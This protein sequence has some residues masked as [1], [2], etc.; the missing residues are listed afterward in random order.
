MRK[1]L[2]ILLAIGI[3]GATF[4]PLSIPVNA[5]ES[6]TWSTNSTSAYCELHKR[7]ASYATAQS[8]A[9]G[10]VIASSIIVVK[11][12][13]IAVGE[14]WEYDIIRSYLYFDTSSLPDDAA[15]TSATLR[16]YGIDKSIFSTTTLQIQNGMP[17]YPSEPLEGGDYDASNYSGNGGTF[18]SSSLVSGAYNDISLTA[19][20]MSW[21]NL[22]GTTKF[23]LRLQTDINAVAPNYIEMMYFYS[24][25]TSDITKRPQLVV[26]YDAP[27]PVVVTRIATNVNPTTATL[28]GELLSLEGADYAVCYFEYGTTT[29]YGTYSPYNM[30]TTIGTF[31]DDISNL[32]I[33]ATYHYRAIALVNGETYLGSDATFNTMPAFGSTTDLKII[34]A[35]IFET[36]TT[37][38]DALVLVE[39]VCNYTDLFPDEL[40]GNYF[41]IQLL[42][43]DGN[44]IIGASGLSAWGARP[45]SIYLKSAIASTLTAQGAYIVRLIG[46]NVSTNPSTSYTL[47]PDDWLGINPEE[48]DNWCRGTAENMA[49]LDGVSKDKY[50]T[51]LTDRR[52]VISDYAG[53]YFTTGIPGISEVRPYL[54]ETHVARA[55]LDGGTADNQ[56]DDPNAWSTNLGSNLAADLTVF[57]APFGATGKQF[58]SVMVFVAMIGVMMM[59]VG[60]LN[61]TGA[62]G[63]FF[64]AIPILWWGTYF[65][66]NGVQVLF[67]I[68]LCCLVALGINVFLSKL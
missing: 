15:I 37:A 4:V 14:G 48:L 3:I 56:W 52:E 67:M 62:L 39:A 10:D 42:S 18:S 12:E 54:F 45:S 30:Y 59:I 68:L 13:K 53:G 29:S 44:T 23:C 57:G 60:G 38:G 63:A 43:T 31:S 41:Q 20:G 36:Y 49:A 40:P 35:K 11:Q 28:Q 33:G 21:I 27:S 22:T 65:K 19:D 46:Y 51:V 64:I 25:L 17:T 66:I 26:T 34:T 2:R 55:T 24:G 50:L 6:I 5:T 47:T 9:T 7:D 8:S 1:L 16:L 58:T 32:I 61:G